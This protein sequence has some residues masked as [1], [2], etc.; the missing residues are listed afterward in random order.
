VDPPGPNSCFDNRIFKNVFTPVWMFGN[1]VAGLKHLVLSSGSRGIRTTANCHGR[2]GCVRR[3][4]KYNDYYLR[5]VCS[6]VGLPCSH[7][8]AQLPL[9]FV[10]SDVRTFT[11]ICRETLN[12]ATIGNFT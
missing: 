5:H 3:I 10:K 8:S 6:S 12:L 2:Y 4:R 11:E 1:A 9:I 7:V